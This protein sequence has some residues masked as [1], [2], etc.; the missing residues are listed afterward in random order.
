MFEAR[1][2]VIRAH[3]VEPRWQP[4]AGAVQLPATHETL[5]LQ[6][7]VTLAVEWLTYFIGRIGAPD[8]NTFHAG[9][10]AEQGERAAQPVAVR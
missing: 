2:V 9:H 4:T 6:L 10:D 7:A 1:T 5:S 8:I 3:D